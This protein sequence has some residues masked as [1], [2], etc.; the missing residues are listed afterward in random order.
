MPRYIKKHKTLTALGPTEERNPGIWVGYD[1]DDVEGVAESHGL[2]PV[3]GWTDE[4]LAARG[5]TTFKR[6]E[7]EALGLERKR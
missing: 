7:P 1:I 4:E 3:D 5:V 2:I 6:V